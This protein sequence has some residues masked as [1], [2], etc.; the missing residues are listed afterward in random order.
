MILQT[1][2]QVKM[3]VAAVTPFVV[4]TLLSSRVNLKRRYRGHQ[5]LLPLVA[6]IYCIVM[7]FATNSVA[8]W[9]A[10]MLDSVIKPLSHLPLIGNNVQWVLN[11]FAG[12][13]RGGYHVQLIANT[14]IMTIFC[15]VKGIM[16]PIT[17]RVW[18]KWSGLYRF[19]S[20]RFYIEKGGKSILK[21]RFGDLRIYLLVMYWLSVAVGAIWCALSFW[22]N[23]LAGDK[24]IFLFPVYPV[25]G[26]I[27]LG[28][29]CFFLHGETLDEIKEE[30]VKD[31]K[32]KKPDPF[33]NIMKEEEKLFKDR[34]LLADIMPP[35][36]A[37]K[38][39][40]R[41]A[42]ELAK[43]D[44]Y[45]QIAGAYFEALANGG[46]NVN[47]D[48]VTATRSLLHGKSVLIYN[49]FY[50]D[51]TDYVM[52]PLFHQLLN[53]KRVLVICGRA[54]NEKEVCDWIRNGVLKI[55]NL[56]KLW[57][58]GSLNEHTI[59]TNILNIGILGFRKLY[60]M[61][62]LAANSAFLREVSF[63]V[64][65]EP[66]NLLGTGQIGLRTIVHLCEDNDKQV[67]YLAIDRNADGLVDALSH[68]VRQPITEVVAAPVAENEY[69]RMMWRAE[70]PGL[71][72]KILPR[73]SHFLGIGGE[74]GSL[75]I[76]EGADRIRWY[77]GSK[78]PVMDLRW[79]IEQY[80]A[81]ICNYLNVPRE[82]FELDRRF[83]FREGLWQAERHEGAFTIVEDEFCNL[84]DISRSFATRE[85]KKGFVN[86]ISESY[87][88]RDYMC[89]NEILFSNDAK[90]IPSIVPDY[91]QTER[92]FVIRMLSL[93]AVSQVPEKVLSKELALQGYETRL[94]YEKFISMVKKYTG[95][96]QV[97]IRRIQ[98][99]ERM[100]G[101]VFINSAYVA[102][103]TY[104]ESIF[105]SALRPAHY[106]V[107]NEKTNIYMMG[108]RLM[109]QVDQTLLE[110][111]LFSYEG[112]YYQVRRISPE[113]GIVVRRAADHLNGRFYY[114][115]I[116]QYAAS[117]LVK[118]NDL[119]E[120]RGIHIV[121]MKADLS[122]NT[123]GYYVMEARHLLKTASISNL[124]APRQ[125]A[126]QHKDILKVEFPDA[127]EGVLFTICDLFN[128]LFQTVYPNDEEYIV[129]VTADRNR[130][131]VSEEEAKRLEALVPGFVVEEDS[132]AVYFIEDS[133]ID[134]GILVS[135]ERN[136]QRFLEIITDYLDWYLDPK[137]VRIDQSETAEDGRTGTEDDGSHG[138]SAGGRPGEAEDGSHGGSADGRPGEAEDGSR[139][140]SSGGRPGEATDERSGDTEDSRIG[141]ARDSKSVE[142]QAIR[143]D[144]S[145]AG[146][147]DDDDDDTEG[148]GGSVD[149]EDEELYGEGGSLRSGFRNCEFLT[150][151][152]DD[153]PEWLKLKETLNYL[154]SKRFDDSNLRRARKGATDFSD[155]ID[156]DPN[157]SGVHY[158]DFCGRVL[159]KGTYDV[160]KDGRERCSE[161]SLTAVKKRKQFK[162]V[163]AQ[164]LMEMEQIF[165]IDLN[166]PVKARMVNARK[167]NDGLPKVKYIPTP[168][169]D[170]R[171]L[172]YASKRRR[173]YILKVENGAP[174]W[175]MKSTLAHE[176]THIWQ[177]SNWTDGKGDIW[178]QSGK[179]HNEIIEGMAVWAE[180]QYLMSMGREEDAVRYM[181]NREREDS[182]YGIGMKRYIARYSISRTGRL[183]NRKT[184]FR[185]YP[186][187]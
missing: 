12:I 24:T 14:L 96:E 81:P 70:G 68:V 87:L 30:E 161:C 37:R 61:P 134:L 93:M 15:A 160:L 180:V 53:H 171:V 168:G 64:L 78:M 127:P 144:Q 141:E 125:R 9:I 187:L 92:N 137:R 18:D 10:K 43:N 89:A 128:E 45:D 109:G 176:L 51:V 146:N 97:G 158:C 166:V 2:A 79:N 17:K 107:E 140:G 85:L 114:R 75:A 135:I 38:Q 32:E 25:F 74:I 185:E 49:P 82:Q 151:G 133:H 4:M 132:S 148:T 117:S 36:T 80:Y 65:L 123:D 165:G 129:A 186:P 16:L 103:K 152:Y 11:K 174:L 3:T 58:I 131:Q 48:Y 159:E 118:E 26:I 20:G 19:T 42:D 139:G 40:H 126:M 104:V 175:K 59:G 28:E 29:F 1:A 66:S 83:L 27:I 113:N 163:Y 46:T 21:D 95:N 100:Q 153:E 122:V 162:K 164:T 67:T 172:G 55:T 8:D 41:W 88:L 62:N 50:H 120:L 108:N 76:H 44:S 102:D 145:P 101:Q 167:V 143:M 71:Q 130:P 31:P 156:Y 169:M 142:G 73:I 115:Q 150:Y 182:E 52:L 39:E 110:G 136:I 72:N 7:I 179:E 86:V 183:I 173:S 33:D 105:D 121:S 124:E 57:K 116:R 91:A 112:R 6:V 84:F 60:D 35:S 34:V 138:G 178:S 56:P 77:A 147:V 22:F 98:N 149:G 155:I 63:V 177:Y 54:M 119:K 13:L 47:P 181:K 94:P 23:D 184:P 69:Y 157:Q 90:A 5:F 111:Q 170:G 154:L 99:N 106:I